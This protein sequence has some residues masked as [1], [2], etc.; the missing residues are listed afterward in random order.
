MI[1]EYYR[2]QNRKL[3]KENIAYGTSGAKWAERVYELCASLNTKDVLDYGCGKQTLKSRIPFV[4]GY[5]PCIEGLDDPPEPAD[6]V[7]CTDVAEHI[8]PVHVD[9]VLDDLKRV[10]RRV[11]FM[12]IATGAAKKFLP[13]GRNAHLTQ[14]GQDYWLPK[15]MSRFYVRSLSDLGGQIVVIC[16]AMPT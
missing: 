6:I 8:E 7:V 3:H 4:R 11:L 16:D 10:T 15:L 12:T 5:D 14:E 1:T 2:E 13:D 9:A